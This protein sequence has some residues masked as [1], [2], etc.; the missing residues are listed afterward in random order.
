[1]Y[2]DF[3]ERLLCSEAGCDVFKLVPC[4]AVADLAKWFLLN[5]QLPREIFLL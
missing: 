5:R 4:P 1:M 2:L 3:G